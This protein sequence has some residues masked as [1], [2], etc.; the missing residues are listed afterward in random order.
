MVFRLGE[1]PNAQFSRRLKH[2]FHRLAV[3]AISAD[4]DSPS[5]LAASRSVGACAKLGVSLCSFALVN[6]RALMV[7]QKKLDGIFDGDDAGGICVLL[8]PALD[9]IHQLS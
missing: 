8:Q 5:A 1:G 2:N 6:S 4:Q 9:D 7:V 3:R